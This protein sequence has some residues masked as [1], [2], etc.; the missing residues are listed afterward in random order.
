MNGEDVLVNGFGNYTSNG[1]NERSSMERKSVKNG[2]VHSVNVQGRSTKSTKCI[3]QRGQVQ[4][5][6]VNIMQSLATLL[7]LSTMLGMRKWV[8]ELVL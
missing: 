2:D 4:L 8:N 5:D 1:G 6:G 3:T 7:L